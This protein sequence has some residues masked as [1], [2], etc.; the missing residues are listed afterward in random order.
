MSPELHERAARIQ[1][2]LMDVDGVLTDGRL[3]HVPV[4]ENGVAR[5]AEFKGFDSQD[6][7]GLQWCAKFGILTGVISGR[8]S[9]ATTERARQNKMKYV[10]QGHTEKIPILQEILTDAKIAPENV[11][12]IG[13]DLTDIV[14]MR[15]VGLAIAVANARPELAPFAHFTT[16]A[17]GG[18]GA[19]REAVEMILTAKGLWQQVL[20]HYEAIQ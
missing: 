1:L 20:T 2:L 18:N 10:Y 16:R 19:V 7:I 9:E 17:A 11:A 15:R 12:Y 13:D 8:L 5:M 14:V 3:F 4:I 6:G